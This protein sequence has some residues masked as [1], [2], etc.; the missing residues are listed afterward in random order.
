[1]YQTA[2]STNDDQLSD[3]VNWDTL[4]MDLEN[5][6]SEKRRDCPFIDY[7]AQESS[8]GGLD[9]DTSFVQ[10]KCHRQRHQLVDYSS[11][12]DNES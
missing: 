2:S 7:E 8:D 6:D 9:S 4:S 10:K 1:M 11:S 12:S 3:I 5:E